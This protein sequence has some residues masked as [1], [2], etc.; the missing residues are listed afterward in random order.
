MMPVYVFSVKA[1]SDYITKQKRPKRK[2][3]FSVSDFLM[4]MCICAGGKWV[5]LMRA[6]MFD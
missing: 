6:L 4:D 5:D 1:E 2:L 3:G